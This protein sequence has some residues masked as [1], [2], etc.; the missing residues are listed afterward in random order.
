M[1]THLTAKFLNAIPVPATTRFVWD[2]QISGLGFRITPNAARAFVL[3][4]YVN[5]NRRRHTIGR[6]PD[7]SVEAA[8]QKA[9]RLKG[10]IA[11][12]H[13]PQAERTNTR[14]APT[15]QQLAEDYL[16]S[17]AK[18]HKRPR[19][20]GM[21]SGCSETSSCQ[22]QGPPGL[23]HHN[24]RYRAAPP[25]AGSHTPS[26]QSGSCPAVAHVQQG[27]SLGLDASQPR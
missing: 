26:C 11:E 3:D 18:L 8:R 1:T 9:I 23:L 22:V 20:S 19:P 17:H 15:M 24:S 27:H 5:G 16:E 7:L 6:F 12:G 2:D 10:R 14:H 13:D 4:Y 21:T 25:E